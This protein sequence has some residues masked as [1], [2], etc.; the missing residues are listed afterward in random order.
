LPHGNHWDFYWPKGYRSIVHHRECDD[1]HHYDE[2]HGR[3]LMT[4]VDGCHWD[5]KHFGFKHWHH[6]DDRDWWCGDDGK[7]W[8]HGDRKFSFYWPHM[9]GFHWPHWGNRK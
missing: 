3:K 9:Y 7:W 5:G 6:D 2:H 1:D 4:F 8:Y